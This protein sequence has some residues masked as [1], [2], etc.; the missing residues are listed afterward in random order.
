[1]D[2]ILKA[3]S[4]ELFR[5]FRITPHPHC[6]HL[7]PQTERRRLFVTLTKNRCVLNIERPL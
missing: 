5:F 6:R 7:L 2:N 1:M 4:L 3:H